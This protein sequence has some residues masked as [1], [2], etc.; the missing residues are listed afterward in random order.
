MKISD[1]VVGERFRK[2]VGELSSLVASIK[3][4]GLLHPIVVS[5]KDELIAGYRRLRAFQVMGLL[6]IP[7]TIVNLK[8][9]RKGQ[10]HENL[11]RK[12]FTA[13]EMVAVQRALETEIK[14]EHPVG[15]PEKG[16]KFP[17]LTGEKT[18][19]VIGSFVG[20]SGR[21]LEKAED[22]VEAAE[23]EPEKY[24]PL[25]VKVDNEK[26]SVDAAYTQIRRGEKHKNM[27]KH[28]KC[29]F[30]EIPSRCL[31]EYARLKKTSKEA[32]GSIE[33]E[34][35]LEAEKLKTTE[36]PKDSLANEEL[37]QVQESTVEEE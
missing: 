32:S 37:T 29:V 3:E 33:N 11:I 25:L 20:V 30:E 1:V 36:D 13:S 16:G 23:Q 9:L 12:N 5:E 26:I 31:E 7:A 34:D 6:E 35:V 15:R 14:A 17:Q 22:I 19:D 21:T 27:R 24:G 4:V 18:R 10:I 8:D 2:D 28:P